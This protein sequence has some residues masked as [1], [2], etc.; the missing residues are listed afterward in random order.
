MAVDN[1]GSRGSPVSAA[2]IVQKIALLT[3]IDRFFIIDRQTLIVVGPSG[4][5]FCHTGILCG[6]GSSS[7]AWADRWE[8]NGRAIQLGTPL[9]R[10]E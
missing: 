9:I 8:S 6:L 2:S 4:L 3:L 5:A 10:S 7:C 1:N